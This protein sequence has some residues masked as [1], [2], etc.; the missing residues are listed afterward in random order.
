MTTQ[1]PK[2]SYVRQ[3]T[4]TAP[5]WECPACGIVYAKYK[6]PVTAAAADMEKEPTPVTREKQPWSFESVTGIAGM[7][8]CLFLLVKGLTSGVSL[9]NGLLLIPFFICFV[10]VLSYTFGDG[11]YQWNR[12]E[13]RFERF[14]SEA[15][16]LLSKCLY[17]FCMVFSLVFAA[18]F[19]MLDR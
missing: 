11:L 9:V 13:M 16:P 7:I 2:C 4:D 6:P 10:P 1:C 14:D 5:D 12:W 3:P 19:F 18:F 17:V 8:C 15:R